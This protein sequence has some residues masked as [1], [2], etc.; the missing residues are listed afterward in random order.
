MK[1]TP[2]FEV[3]FIVDNV[4]NKQPPFPAPSPARAATS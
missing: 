3:R 2:A 1:V 4:F